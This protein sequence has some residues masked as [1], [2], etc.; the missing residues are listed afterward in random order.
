RHLHRL[1]CAFPAR[2][3][4]GA[5]VERH[6][7]VSAKRNLNL[8]GS[9][10]SEEVARPIKMRAKLDA[11]L[12]DFAQLVQAE[13]LESAGVGKNAAFPR[14]KPVQP[15]HFA[16]GFMSGPE[17]EVIRV[18][19][20]NPNAELFQ[21]VLR[22]AFDGTK[23]SDRHEDWS[24]DLAVRSRDLAQASGTVSGVNGEN[25]SCHSE[26]LLLRR[27]IPAVTFAL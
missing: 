8:H 7:D 3:M 15:A 2:R 19:E 23:R 10:R 13:N 6:D 1:S 17:I 16:D 26:T 12:T 27:G 20:K 21:N 18:A 22:H 4:L 24:L 5:F 25:A 9:L 11:A 14:H